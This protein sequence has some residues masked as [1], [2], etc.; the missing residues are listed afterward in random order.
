MKIFIGS[1]SE[2]ES[3][4]NRVKEILKK[5]NMSIEIEDWKSDNVFKIGHI[6]YDDLMKKADEVDAA[7]FIFQADDYIINNRNQEKI[8]TCNPKAVRDNVVLEY[9]LF[10][11]KLGI[12]R[13][14]IA[15]KD[16]PKPTTDLDGVVY[17]DLEK[18]DEY[19]LN[20]IKT[21]IFE[22]D[23]DKEF[24]DTFNAKQMEIKYLKFLRECEK[25]YILVNDLDYLLNKDEQESQLD[26]I[27]NKKEN[28]NILCLKKDKENFSIEMIE[29]IRELNKNKVG[30]FFYEKGKYEITNIKGQVRID[31][32]GYVQSLII[33]K[34]TGKNNPKTL[35]AFKMFNVESMKL[36]K[37]FEKEIVKV[38][39]QNNSCYDGILVAFDGLNE[40]TQ[41]TMLEKIND[42]LKE[43]IVKV[44]II[45]QVNEL[46][47]V[48]VDK[49][50][51]EVGNTDAMD[52]I[53]A[54]ERYKNLEL[55][56]KPLL[57]KGYIVLCD[58]YIA[59]SFIS[60]EFHND[61]YDF[62]YGLNSHLIQPDIQIFLYKSQSK[63]IDKVMDYFNK[64]KIYNYKFDISNNIE[65]VVSEICNLI[66]RY[67][68]EKL[69]Y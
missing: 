1:S 9:G 54:G 68:A 51:F 7:I 32:N 29:L 14:M 50:Y 13:V 24:K 34:I 18:D 11:G 6:I 41:S 46:S 26:I 48:E 44:E 37:W 12:D 22:L 28:A 64:E 15:A 25:V 42:K 45:K 3:Q 20:R 67:K 10:S 61:N 58:T 53:I 21:W 69:L 4:M 36:N 38:C 65:E 31:E 57:K 59:S 52:C 19:I 47:M 39:E 5:L 35:S 30:L 8:D 40:S 33:D 43:E 23:E 62:I 16:N 56:I 66:F 17:V 49:Q 55:K 27:K 2:A 60:K 63:T